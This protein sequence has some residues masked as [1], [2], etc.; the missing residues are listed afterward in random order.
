MYNNLLLNPVK[1]RVFNQVLE[2][3][4]K[5]SM[6]DKLLKSFFILGLFEQ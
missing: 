6:K 1:F 4:D 3:H 5:H 2:Q